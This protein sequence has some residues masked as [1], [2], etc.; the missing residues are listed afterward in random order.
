[1]Q[2]FSSFFV[3][4]NS[5]VNHSKGW[6]GLN[7]YR[8]SGIDSVVSSDHASPGSPESI[9]CYHIVLTQGLFGLE[10]VES[11]IWFGHIVKQNIR[12]SRG[13]SWSVFD[14]HVQ[15]SKGMK[16]KQPTNLV[17][18]ANPLRI[19][20]AEYTWHDLNLRQ[21]VCP[22]SSGGSRCLFDSRDD[23]HPDVRNCACRLVFTP[24]SF[25]LESW[26]DSSLEKQWDNL[27]VLWGSDL[28]LAWSLFWRN[29]G[30]VTPQSRLP[31]KRLAF[32][33]GDTELYSLVDS[34]VV[35]METLWI[36]VKFRGSVIASLGHVYILNS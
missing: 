10:S 25:V 26:K 30:I 24:T 4:A 21:S 33:E 31:R 5:R 9:D 12:T 22:K 32:G 7:R 13:L 11:Q 14:L 28:Y 1:M 16:D 23:K 2:T 27:S 20:S 36:A 6:G 34:I 19:K 35:S 17:N 3:H 15:L 8:A 29:P 18:A